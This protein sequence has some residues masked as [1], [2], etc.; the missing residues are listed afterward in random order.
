[1]S[2]SIGGGPASA[3][4][5]AN[6]VA[7]TPCWFGGHDDGPRTTLAFTP[8]SLSFAL[9]HGAFS[10]RWRSRRSGISIRHCIST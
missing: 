8:G 4:A 9:S 2:A 6:R 10:K 5:R 3:A 1:M 7:G